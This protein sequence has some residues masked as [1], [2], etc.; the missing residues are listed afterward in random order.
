MEAEKTFTFTYG[1]SSPEFFVFIVVCAYFIS[2]LYWLILGSIGIIKYISDYALYQRLLTEPW[3]MMLFYSSQFT[4]G[5][6]LILR[7]VGSFFALHSAFL[8][9]RQKY[10]ILPLI[11]GKVCVA[12]LLEACYYLC[13]IP[14]VIV[15][16]VYPFTDEKLWYSDTT[17]GL[18][19]LLVAG[20]AS[21]A[22]VLTIPPFLLKL[23]SKIMRGSSNYEVLKWSCLAGISYLFIVFWFNYSLAWVATM[24]PYWRAPGPSG[25]SVLFDPINLVS[26]LSTIVGL[27]LIAI[28]GLI[29]VLPNIRQFSTKLDLKSLGIT[30]TAFGL[31]F[32]LNIFLYFLAGG[33]VGRP[34][35]WSEIIGPANT[36]LWCVTFLFLGLILLFRCKSQ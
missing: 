28:F 36:N 21:L 5:A 31:Y 18:V 2:A 22:M 11:K 25:L 4:S 33:Y 17:P 30:M 6:G 1:A 19:V 8:F 26:F 35:V 9:L 34:T 15:G 16:F 27:L 23:R 20:V 7:G 12:L 24:V 29:S 10:Y 32:I 14:S 3:W 13:F